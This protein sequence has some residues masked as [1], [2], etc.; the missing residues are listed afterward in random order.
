MH[1]LAAVRWQWGALP[2]NVAGRNHP[3]LPTWD[4][5]QILW[6]SL[7]PLLYS[8]RAASSESEAA[9]GPP[10]SPL[11]SRPNNP[12]LVWVDQPSYI[13]P[14]RCFVISAALLWALSPGCISFGCIVAPKTA[15]SAHGG[16]AVVWCRADNSFPCPA[17]NVVLGATQQHQQHQSVAKMKPKCGIQGWS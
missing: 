3:L 9:M 11:F 17:G 2:A 1:H 8:L 5:L 6:A 14:S 12:A 10:L 4:T 15:L 16:A 7:S 13:F